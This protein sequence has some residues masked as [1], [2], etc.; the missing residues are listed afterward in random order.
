MV[1][2]F[3]TSSA[4]AMGTSHTN[5][6]SN[7]GWY[8]AHGANCLK[9]RHFAAGSAHLNVIAAGEV[10]AN[11]GSLPVNT[12]TLTNSSLKYGMFPFTACS[13]PT[14]Y[15]NPI[16]CNAG[17]GST[18]EYKFYQAG[19]LYARIGGMSTGVSI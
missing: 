18:T 9:Q 10:I 19:N 16:A 12:V 3:G 17:A 8:A 15:K 2:T 6:T 4:D 11:Y 14:G 13:A 1:T 5:G 7:S